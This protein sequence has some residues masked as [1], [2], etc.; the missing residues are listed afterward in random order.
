MGSPLIAFDDWSGLAVFSGGTWR[1]SLPLSNL[2]Q[3]ELGRLARS[4]SA[5]PLATWFDVDLVET[6]R[7]VR[8]LALLNHNISL[9]GSTY[10]L[11]GAR[12]PTFSAPEIDTGAAVWPRVYPM[13]ARNWNAD[14]FWFGTYTK[15]D[16]K[17]LPRHLFVLLDTTK[18]LRYWRLEISDPGN[19]DGYVQA[20]GFF[21]GDA[22]QAA[23]GSP[24]GAS[25]GWED[26]T[27]SVRTLSGAKYPDLKQPFRVAN[28]TTQMMTDDEMYSQAFEIQRRA[29]TG[30]RVL[31][32]HD[33]D[34]T[35]HAVRG[36]FPATIRTLG[37]N[38]NPYP[39]AHQAGWE[40]E[41][42]LP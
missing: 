22:W 25:I 16:L 17:R 39:N 5:D 30:R 34:A 6:G 23:Q 37:K 15:D 40:F 18:R 19:A 35:L 1:G 28:I 3:S 21:L 36:R 42:E 38:E 11:R 20:G 8:V 14:N 41:E 10:R 2:G 12:E 26:P 9:G 31:Y 13:S 32:I 24:Y 27:T 33:P 29:G 4:A 7:P